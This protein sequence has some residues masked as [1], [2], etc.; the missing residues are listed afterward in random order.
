[1]KS[2]K[3][4]K[5][6]L[7]ALAVVL[8]LFLVTLIFFG[9]PPLNGDDKIIKQNIKLLVI[10]SALM[11]YQKDHGVLPYYANDSEKAF[12]L[13]EEY[14]PEAVEWYKEEWSLNY[15]EKAYDINFFHYDYINPPNM[16]TAEMIW[17][18][19]IIEK[20]KMKRGMKQCLASDGSVFRAPISE[21]DDKKSN[22]GNIVQPDGTIIQRPSESATQQ[23]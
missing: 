19:I 7:I 10:H 3:I 21:K 5:G 1:M 18:T 13:I 17:G 22:L 8:F 15:K 2:K 6:Y 20:K 4:R 9:P 12:S 14:V 23:N 11:L 16:N